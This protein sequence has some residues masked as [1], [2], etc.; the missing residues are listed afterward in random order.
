MCECSMEWR[1]EQIALTLAILQRERRTPLLATSR[2]PPT[3]SSIPDNLSSLSPSS[4]ALDTLCNIWYNVSHSMRG[5][6]VIWVTPL[7]TS[8]L[9]CGVAPWC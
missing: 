6:T 8:F 9:N 2:I 4:D 7:R 5:G 3:H 1:G